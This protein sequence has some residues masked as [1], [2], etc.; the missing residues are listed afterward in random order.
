MKANLLVESRKRDRSEWQIDQY[1][2]RAM[3]DE[4]TGTG[5]IQIYCSHEEIDWLFFD[6]AVDIDGHQMEFHQVSRNTS[7]HTKYGV[8]IIED[9]AIDVTRD[10]LTAKA[11]AGLRIRV[12]GK[13]GDRTLVIPAFYIQGFLER[14]DTFAVEPS[15]G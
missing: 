12:Y 15:K 6:H 3:R 8:G 5:F 14:Y 2:L 4:S 11:A 13:S 10:Y 7:Q 9:F 1:Y